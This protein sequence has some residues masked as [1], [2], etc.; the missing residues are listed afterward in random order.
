MEGTA[1]GMTVLKKMEQSSQRIVVLTTLY[2]C[3]EWID[4]CIQSIKDQTYDNYKCFILDDMSTDSSVE[5]AKK[6]IGDDPRFVIVQN[7]KKYYQT[8]NYDQIIRSDQVQDD[9]ICVEVD[10]DDWLPDSGVFDRVIDTYSEGEIWI[11]FGQFRY[12][13]GR[14]GFAQQG[15]V[16]QCRTSVFTMSHLRTWKAFLWRSIQVEDL[17]T[18]TGWYSD[19]G[20]DVFFM[21]PMYEMA[22]ERH[23][24]FMEGINYVYNDDNPLNDHKRESNPQHQH[25]NFARSKSPYGPLNFGYNLLTPY[26]FDLVPKFLYASYK[27]AKLKTDFAVDIY[28]EHLRVWNGFK[29]YDNPYKNTFEKFKE[30]FDNLIASM[31]ESGFDKNYPVPTTP[32]GHLLNGSHRT[33][34]AYITNSTLRTQKTTEPSAGQLD[35]G[36]AFF[37]NLGLGKKHLD[38]IALEY[39]KL[40]PSTKVITLHPVRDPSK[41]EAVT[42][43]IYSTTE[44]VYDSVVPLEKIGFTRFMSQMYLGESWLSTPQDPIAGAKIKAGLCWGSTPV[45]VILIEEAD[46]EKVNSLKSNI[47]SIYNID[48]SSVHINDTHE[49][50]LRLARVIYNP[51]SVYFLNKGNPDF[52]EKLSIELNKYKRT[53]EGNNLNSDLFCV[54]GS[55]VMSLFGLRECAD[56]DYLHYN[57]NH[58]IKGSSYISSH[59]NELSKYPMHKDDILFNPNNHFYWNNIKFATLDVVKSLKAHRGEAKDLVDVKLVES[60]L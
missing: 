26:R 34:A 36:S 55:A 7:T 2:N 40:K 38:F 60:I 21:T 33:A 22:T 5:K 18:Y 30:C 35:C 32:E 4:K 56:L 44:V 37:R 48:K 54:T 15:S 3:E 13:D 51:N 29:E 6:S 59:E 1:K 58:I 47:R 43:L 20:G 24:K 8:G 23:T 49:E 50:T 19:G 10:G 14:K 42:D 25:A 16:A 28:K 45:R 9:D 31:R 27:E 57:P 53:I 17:Y 39:A 11:A 52:S 46:L 12:A 41:E